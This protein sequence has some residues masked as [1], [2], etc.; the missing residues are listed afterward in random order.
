M[1]LRL[2]C[3]SVMVSHANMQAHM[4]TC[5]AQTA[6]VAATERWQKLQWHGLYV[7]RGYLST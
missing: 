2:T 3:P 6:E 1:Q 7:L 5:K 4:I